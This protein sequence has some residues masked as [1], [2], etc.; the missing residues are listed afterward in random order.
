MNEIN[1]RMLYAGQASCFSQ[2]VTFAKSGILATKE[3]VKV[4][5]SRKEEF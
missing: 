4:Y 3:F 2:A 1:A 5:S